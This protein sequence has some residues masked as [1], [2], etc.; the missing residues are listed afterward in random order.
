MII[1]N[2][3]FKLT[4]ITPEEEVFEGNAIKLNCETTEGRMGVLPNHC[5][6]V[7]ALTKSETKFEDVNHKKY[8]IFTSEGIL[9]INNNNVILLCDAVKLDDSE[10]TTQ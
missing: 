6:M 2:N 8:K 10:K 5:A 1:L 7:A 4:I 3:F 9:K